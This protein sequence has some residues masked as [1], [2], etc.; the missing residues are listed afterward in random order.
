[1]ADV[2]AP[3]DQ[4]P[5]M[6]PPIRADDQILPHIRMPIPGRLV[7]ANIREASYYQ[8]Y[9]ENVAKHR[10]FLAGETRSTQ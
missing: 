2:N 1:M 7:T 5:T 3:S 9:Q 6:A 10:G 4:T 8:E